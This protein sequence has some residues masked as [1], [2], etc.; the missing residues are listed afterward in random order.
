M[1]D[2][3]DR[4]RDHLTFGLILVNLALDNSDN[5]MLFTAVNQI[6][7]GGASA[8]LGAQ[9]YATMAKYNM[10]AGKRAMEMSDFQSAFAFFSFGIDFLPYGH[11]RLH[12]DLS[13]ELYDLASKSALAAGNIGSLKVL[14]DE[15]LHNAKSFEDK[16]TV[17]SIMVSSLA[18]ASKS[19]EALEQG[20][21]I[22]SRL[23]ED[24][25]INP[26]KEALDQQIQQT[27]SLIKGISEHDIL[28]FRLTTDKTKLAAMKFLAQL[29][30]T[31]LMVKPSLHPFVTLRMVQLTM[32]NGVLT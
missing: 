1:I 7:F 2:E 14:A 23:G 32:S 11:W 29:E 17:Y 15:V 19:L 5:E 4:T 28:N 22:L 27:Q 10:M 12:Y 26:S 16:L 21:K 25:P 8:V 18:Y 3:Q 9:E 6:N 13:L 31:T 24:I 30:N 20:H